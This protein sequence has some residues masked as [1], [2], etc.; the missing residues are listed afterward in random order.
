MNSPNEYGEKCSIEFRI[1]HSGKIFVS[2]SDIL[3]LYATW[4]ADRVLDTIKLH[5]SEL[6]NSVQGLPTHPDFKVDLNTDA[7]GEFAALDTK[8]EAPKF[9][10]DGPIY[11]FIR[12]DRKSGRGWTL[13]Y[14]GAFSH[15]HFA[16]QSLAIYVPDGD[17]GFTT[18]NARINRGEFLNIEL[19]GC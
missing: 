3:K 4:P 11:V 14:H 13:L 19:R 6:Q 9:R 15:I 16:M 7:P 18:H 17:G 12:V 5:L 8:S 1:D 10:E 2:A